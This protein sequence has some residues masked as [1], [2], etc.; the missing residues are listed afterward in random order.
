[1]EMESSFPAITLEREN[2]FIRVTRQNA[3]LFALHGMVETVFVN[4]TSRSRDIRKKL[5]K[6]CINTYVIEFQTQNWFFAYNS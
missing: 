3:Q 6:F 2:T 5:L 4:L 1:M